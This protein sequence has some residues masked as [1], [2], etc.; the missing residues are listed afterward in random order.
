MQVPVPGVSGAEG[1]EKAGRP[2]RGRLKEVQSKYAGRRTGTGDAG[3]HT[4]DEWDLLT[5]SSIRGGVCLYKSGVHASKVLCRHFSGG[6]CIGV[7]KSKVWM[8]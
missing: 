2:A 8:K 1:E 7:S 5:K 4:W 6:P 3:W